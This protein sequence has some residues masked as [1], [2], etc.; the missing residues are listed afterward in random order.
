MRE[1]MK[2]SRHLVVAAALFA[3]GFLAF[4]VVRALLVPHGFGELGHYRAGALDDNRARA[5]A[6]AGN[7]ACEECHSDVAETKA[8]SK[9][10]R[11]RCEACHGAL[12]EHA[13][14]PSA[15]KPDR[16]DAKK[17]CL[18]CHLA[19]V[20]KPA[21]FPQVDPAEHGG[22]EACSTC[23]RHHHPELE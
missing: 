18:T 2:D 11:V 4:L 17:L 20:G 8:Q 12:A 7:T 1:L 14:D 15:V 6:F 23:H 22:G 3:G 19:N 10:R 16:P 9:H 13:S 21:S 5:V